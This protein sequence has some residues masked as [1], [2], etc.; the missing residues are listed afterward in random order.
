M[1][2]ASE[3]PNHGP[4]FVV[5]DIGCPYCD[6]I[7]KA[8]QHGRN[9]AAETVRIAAYELLMKNV[10]KGIT[11]EQMADMAIAAARGHAKPITVKHPIHDLDCYG[12]PCV[13]RDC[14]CRKSDK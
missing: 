6:A 11:W 14:E 5:E 10:G 3:C 4:V 12:I 13:C 2:H 1:S 7:R 8:Y 9:D